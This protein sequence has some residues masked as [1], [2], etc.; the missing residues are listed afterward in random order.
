MKLNPYN[1][2]SVNVSIPFPSG[3]EGESAMRWFNLQNCGSETVPLNKRVSKKHQ[4]R[5]HRLHAGRRYRFV[6]QVTKE[7]DWMFVGRKDI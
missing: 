1:Q 2:F 3:S 7:G 4:E 5:A 6:F